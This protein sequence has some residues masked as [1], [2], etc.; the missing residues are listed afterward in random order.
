MFRVHHRWWNGV[1]YFYHHDPWR[2]LPNGLSTNQ[3][4]DQM[5]NLCPLEVEISTYHFNIHKIG[6]VSY[7]RVFFG[8]HYRWRNGVDHV[9]YCVPW[10]KLS[11][12]LLNN[13]NRDCI[14]TLHPMEV[15]VPTSHISLHKT[16]GISSYWFTFMLHHIK[17]HGVVSF[18]Y[19]S[20]FR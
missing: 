9:H 19:F 6:G 13:P 1:V 2:D 5:Q 7:S 14:K 17:M 15:D 12:G 20:P 8:V 10:R 4:R 3:N 11:N 16:V 18:H